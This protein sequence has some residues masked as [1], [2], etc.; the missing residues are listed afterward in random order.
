[1]RDADRQRP[2][3]EEERIRQGRTA[4]KLAVTPSHELSNRPADGPSCQDTDRQTDRQGDPIFKRRTKR[5]TEKL[6][7]YPRGQ[8]DYP[9]IQG[10]N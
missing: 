5:Q 9:D 1:M 3:V 6:T 2:R 4:R 8:I 10:T 7:H